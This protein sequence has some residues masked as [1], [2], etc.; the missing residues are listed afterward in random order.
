MVETLTQQKLTGTAL[1]KQELVGSAY[2]MEIVKSICEKVV[3][4]KR[5]SDTVWLSTAIK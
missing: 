5:G 1:T 2:F 3:R 4:E